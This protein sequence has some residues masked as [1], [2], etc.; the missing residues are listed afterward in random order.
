[1]KNDLSTKCKSHTVNNT[2]LKPCNSNYFTFSQVELTEAA[3]R[4]INSPTTATMRRFL[5]VSRA[6]KKQ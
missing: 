2:F 1:M 4:R 3:G 5:H 6:Q